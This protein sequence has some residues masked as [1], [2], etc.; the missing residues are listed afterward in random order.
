MVV[1]RI[2]IW[3]C[4]TIAVD[5][6]IITYI[7]IISPRHSARFGD[8]RL[9]IPL[10]NVRNRRRAI[11]LKNNAEVETLSAN[12]TYS[13]SMTHNVLS[14]INIDPIESA[15]KLIPLGLCWSVSLS[16]VTVF[17]LATS[18]IVENYGVSESVFTSILYTN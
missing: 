14:G 13:V 5:T 10:I 4:P 8:N 15:L 3:S 12:L 7:V 9:I 17:N 2:C 6:T 18:G 11:A 1:K 16:W